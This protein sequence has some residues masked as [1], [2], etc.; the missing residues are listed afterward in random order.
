[1]SNFA[2]R[3]VG[4]LLTFQLVNLYGVIFLKI[5]LISLV[6]LIFDSQVQIVNLL[7]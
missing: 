4:L 3:L 7:L 1:M 2:N 6:A 5:V